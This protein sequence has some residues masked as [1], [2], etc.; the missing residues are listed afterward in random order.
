MIGC[1]QVDADRNIPWK[2]KAGNDNA[3][4]LKQFKETGQDALAVSRW[5]S[6]DDS[7]VGVRKRPFGCQCRGT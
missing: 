1:L 7:Y 6:F 5:G 4:Y 2:M 3:S